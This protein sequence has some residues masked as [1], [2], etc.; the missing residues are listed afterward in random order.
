M[1]VPAD[2]GGG[3]GQHRGGVLAG[4]GHRHHAPTD[5]ADARCR[6]PPPNRR[7]SRVQPSPSSGGGRPALRWL[8]LMVVSLLALALASAPMP[9]PSSVP[10]PWWAGTGVRAPAAAIGWPTGPIL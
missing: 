3:A 4:T 7:R 8:P 1:G 9:S 2:T 5:R 10:G 6:P